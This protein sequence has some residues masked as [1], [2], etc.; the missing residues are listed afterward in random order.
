MK[1]R[2]SFPIIMLALAVVACGKKDEPVNTTAAGVAVQPF[3]APNPYPYPNPNPGTNDLAQ[4]CQYYGGQLSGSTCLISRSQQ[5]S[6]TWFNIS[7][8]DF[9]T[10]VP[11]YAGERVSINMSGSAR[12]YVGGYQYGTGS[13]TFVSSSNG[14]LTLQKYTS[15]YNLQSVSVQSCFNAP[16]QRVSCP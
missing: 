7:I 4:F 8:G 1:L 13:G 16:N 9:N 10:G 12:I 2:L 5:Q 3:P 15:T 14:Y 6:S 11:V